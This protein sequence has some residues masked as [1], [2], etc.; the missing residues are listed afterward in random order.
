MS[1]T[2]VVRRNVS[3]R[4]IVNNQ[5]TQDS[6]SVVVKKSTGESITLNSLKNVDTTDLQDGYTLVYDNDTNKWVSQYINLTNVGN[7]D[8]GTY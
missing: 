5:G 6:A 8:G 3:N 1:D 4:I 2:V 7:L